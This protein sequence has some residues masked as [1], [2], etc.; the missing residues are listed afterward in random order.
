MRPEDRESLLWALSEIADR[1]PR[2]D[3]EA[4]DSPL[5]DSTLR[6]YREGRLSDDEIRRVERRLVAD[7]ACRRR[8]EELAGASPDAPLLDVRRRLL[9]DFGEPAPRRGP[10]R[11]TFWRLGLAAAAMIAL[12]SG[13]LI[14]RPRTAALPEYEVRIAAL[15]ERRDAAATGTVAEAY[16]D[17]TVTIDATVAGTAVEGVEIGVYR[18]SGGRLERVAERELSRLDRYGAVR[19]E[20]PAAVLVGDQPGVHEIFVVIAWRGALPA[21]PA[22]QPG[23]DPA[24]ALAAGGRQVH[25]LILR[26]VAERS[27]TPVTTSPEDRLAHAPRAGHSDPRHHQTRRSH[28][29]PHTVFPDSP[30]FVSTTKF[31]DHVG[32]G[33]FDRLLVNA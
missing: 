17:S 29:Q 27:A 22:L 19:I 14:L 6:A 12:A 24:E 20:A 26:L 7:P 16:A 1:T 5:P 30:A 33:P 2:D 23:S 3:V 9:E 25:R 21:S 11:S 10:R 32:S 8:L 28:V 31:P 4:G 18:A 13:W 15:A